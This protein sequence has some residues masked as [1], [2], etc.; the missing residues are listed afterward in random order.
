MSKII[1]TSR[2]IKSSRHGG[3]FVNYIATRD[4]VEIP[5]IINGTRPAT[6]N[7]QKLIDEVVKA[8]PELAES[9]EYL[10]Y[11]SAPT[12]ENASE[13]ITTAFEQNP[14]LWDNVRNYVEYIA[15]R[16]GAERS[17]ASGH[18]LW[19]GNKEPVDLTDVVNEVADHQG[20]L[21]THVVSLRREDAER[22][23]Y[24]SAEVWRE[25]VKSKL[26]VI[27]ESMKIPL[28]ELH[29]YGAFHNTSHHPH[30]HLIVYS[31]NP[32]H[33]FLTEPNI[34]RMRSE[35]GTAIFEQD[36]LHIYERKDMVRS[37]FNQFATER[38]KELTHSLDNGN[39][40]IAQMLVSLGEQL[41]QV[42]GKKQ[43]GY[44]KSAL[45]QQVDEIVKLLASDPH[46]DE[47]Y[48]HWC[49][50][51]ADVKRIY[52]SKVDAPPPLE[53]EKTFRT[54][55]N[56]IIRQ[57]IT[58]AE[59][60][61]NIRAPDAVP[62]FADIPEPEFVESDGVASDMENNTGGSIPPTAPPIHAGIGYRNTSLDLSHYAGTLLRSLARLIQSDYEQQRQQYEHAVDRKLMAKIRRKQQDMG[63]KFE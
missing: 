51:T 59:M 30:I 56:V 34:S 21:W 46:I 33:G 18:G 36:L 2:Y 44:L 1:F 15:R 14:E 41:Q 57:A 28:N 16:P 32:S 3:N 54:I 39:P 45:K 49:E 43:Y 8:V 19:N 26:P 10:D 27:A 7:Q 13:F 29:W 40:E 62:L 12:V 24:N 61:L 38:L 23:G 53:Y 37:Q 9:F 22:L 31:Q 25:L 63:Q 55:K 5:K 6:Q 4:G 35:F 60:Q 47:M 52:T 50:L 20:N 48:R 58:M 42:K 11:M 17:V